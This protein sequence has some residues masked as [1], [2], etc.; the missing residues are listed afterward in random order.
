MYTPSVVLLR[1][2][3]LVGTIPVLA[4]YAIYTANMVLLRS[5]EGG[6]CHWLETFPHLRHVHQLYG[7]VPEFG[8]YTPNVVLL[9]SS[10]G[11][12]WLETF[13]YLRHMHQLYGLVPEFGIY[14]LTQRNSTYTIEQSF[15]RLCT[16]HFHELT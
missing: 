16:D 3:S 12:H 11:D 15:T 8:I 1:R 9:R 4:A 2:R 14:L 5:S 7:L 6:H 10:D 13:P